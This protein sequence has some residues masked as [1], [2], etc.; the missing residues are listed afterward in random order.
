MSVSSVRQASFFPLRPPVRQPRGV[1]PMTDGAPQ[2]APVRPR[3]LP[4][5]REVKQQ[6]LEAQL[7]G[8]SA[9]KVRD[10]ATGRPDLM[11][12]ASPEQRARMTRVLL[13]RLF[14][15]AADRQAIL[16][17]L[18]PALDLGEFPQTLGAVKV[19]GRLGALFRQMGDVDEGLDLART[20]LRAGIYD[21]MAVIED[22]GRTGTRAVVRVATD[23][24]LDAMAQSSKQA[25]IATLQSG[26]SDDETEVMIRR[27]RNHLA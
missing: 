23:E 22:L 27:L 3:T 10:L 12:A 24:Q 21:D 19:T 26:P 13:D 1:R 20:G 8:A 2:T 11:E 25:M 7:K 4:D 17:V 9:N 6:L 14:F 15:G 16:A 18:K 5:P